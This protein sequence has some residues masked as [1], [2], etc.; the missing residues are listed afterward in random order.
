MTDAKDAFIMELRKERGGIVIPAEIAEIL[1]ITLTDDVGVDTFEKLKKIDPELFS[2]AVTQVTDKPMVQKAISAW[3]KA[4]TKKSP[5]VIDLDKLDDP[6]KVGRGVKKTIDTDDE[7]EDDGASIIGKTIS[8]GARADRLAELD[9]KITGMS[10]AQNQALSA[11]L[12][13]GRVQGGEVV[14]GLAYGADI[15]STGSGKQRQVE[16]ERPQ[17]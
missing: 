16:Q 9:S 6:R 17:A 2:E 11:S 12:H 4:A 1:A 5:K 8:G 13:I 3:F 14:E 10:K 7:E 15:S